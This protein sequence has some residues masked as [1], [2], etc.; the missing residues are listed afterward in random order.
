MCNHVFGKLRARNS[1]SFPH[2]LHNHRAPVALPEEPKAI[3][4][5]KKSADKVNLLKLL[6][7][8]NLLSREGTLA[9]F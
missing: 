6:Q 5:K 8:L 9:I 4:K 2:G 1:N 3:Q 7:Q